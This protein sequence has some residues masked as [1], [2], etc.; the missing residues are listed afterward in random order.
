M[1]ELNSQPSGPTHSQ[2]RAMIS[3][4]G[5]DPCA[6]QE[7]ARR[8]LLSLG[9]LSVPML[10]EGSEAEHMA[11]R[12]RCR[13]VLREI[14][15]RELLHRLSRLRLGQIG[16]DSASGLLEGAMIVTQLVRTFAPESRK[17]AAKLRREANILRRA[18]EG[19][20][21]PMCAKLLA[22]RLHQQFDLKSCDV[23]EIDVDHVLVDRTLARGVGAPIALSFLY[24]LVARWAGLSAAG[25]ALPNHFLVRIHGPRPLLLDPFHGGRVI[26]KADCARYLRATGFERVR[27]HLRDLT[28]RELLIHYLRS[29]RRASNR[30][31]PDVRTVLGK[32]LAILE[33][34]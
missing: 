25:V 21:L 34:S 11:T 29:L 17:V 23:D 14:E 7:S 31:H 28:D 8:Y 12:T 22:E 24:L 19:R 33:A 4:L 32:A 30:R 9:E 1:T 27:E 20:S 3:V 18:F 5:D 16:R 13:A 26:P 15:V 6:L 2:I 10:R